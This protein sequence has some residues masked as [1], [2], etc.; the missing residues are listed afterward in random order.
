M[1]VH[2]VRNRFMTVLLPFERRRR[3]LATR[4]SPGSHPFGIESL[5]AAA[6]S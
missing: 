5:G 1:P 2:N 3:L 4:L 6:P